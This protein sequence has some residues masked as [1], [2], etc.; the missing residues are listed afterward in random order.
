MNPHVFLLRKSSSRWDGH[1]EAQK[2]IP[3]PSFIICN[4]CFWCATVIQDAAVESCPN[5]AT[6][7]LEAIPLAADEKFTISHSERRGLTIEFLRRDA[8]AHYD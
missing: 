2:L 7:T 8:H 3:N 4:D 1:A 6:N 5:C